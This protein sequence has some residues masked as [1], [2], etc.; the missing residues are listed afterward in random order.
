MYVVTRGCHDARTRPVD[1][2]GLARGAAGGKVGYGELG[3]AHA[4]MHMRFGAAFQS[5]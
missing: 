3:Q 2:E 5:I 1:G 4:Q